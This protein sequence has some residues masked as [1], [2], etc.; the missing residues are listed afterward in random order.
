M[1][2]SVII[3]LIVAA[4][5][6]LLGS[7]LIG[8]SF[9]NEGDVLGMLNTKNYETSTYSITGTFTHILITDSDADIYIFFQVRI[10]SAELNAMNLYGE[11]T[12]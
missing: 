5:L 4:S 8:I 11:G 7:A 6:I 10:A 9:V 12:A 3:W 2:K 1:K